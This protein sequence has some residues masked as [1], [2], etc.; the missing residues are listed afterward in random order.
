M[1]AEL[2]CITY[3]SYRRC[4]LRQCFTAKAKIFVLSWRQFRARSAVRPMARSSQIPL[5]ARRQHIQSRIHRRAARV[6]PG[7]AARAT[8]SKS[9]A[10]PA[11]SRFRCRC[12]ASPA[13]RNITRDH[14]A[15]RRL[16]GQD[17][18]TRRKFC[19]PSPTRSCASRWK[20]TCPL[21]TKSSPS[22]PRPRR[23]RAAWARSS[24]A[25]REAAAGRAGAGAC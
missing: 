12:S 2:R 14:R 4:R 20:P 23:A 16:A 8:R 6:G 17:R 18:S 1:A 25:A 15:R 21:S 10:C 11:R 22:A 13:R 3:L 9:S 19:A 5:C 7:R 24:T